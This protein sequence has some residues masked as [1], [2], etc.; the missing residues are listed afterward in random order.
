MFNIVK[1]D[2]DY[3]HISL[4]ASIHHG[5]G[6]RI[7]RVR[8]YMEMRSMCNLVNVQTMHRIY[9]NDRCPDAHRNVYNIH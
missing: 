1:T 5:N 8:G 2:C 9:I 3:M 6:S 7:L 4:W